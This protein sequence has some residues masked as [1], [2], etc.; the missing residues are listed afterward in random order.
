MNQ[1]NRAQERKGDGHGDRF[2]CFC[3]QN[4]F[5][6]ASSLGFFGEGGKGVGCSSKR[7]GV[8]MMEMEQQVCLNFNLC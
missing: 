8:L 3:E 2:L 5:L 6:H 4:L 7:A 1:T